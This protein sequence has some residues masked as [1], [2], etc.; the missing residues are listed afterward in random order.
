LNVQ[1]KVTVEGD[2]TCTPHHLP[3]R[4][5]YGEP[6]SDESCHYHHGMLRMSHHVPFCI[7]LRCQHYQTMMDAYRN[8]EFS[9]K[10]PTAKARG[11]VQ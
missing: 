6:I 11:R 9:S 2:A 1:D 8:K 7:L 10:E 4:L 3:H 5:P